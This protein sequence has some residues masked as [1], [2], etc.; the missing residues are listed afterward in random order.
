MSALRGGANTCVTSLMKI[1][2]ADLTLITL[3]DNLKWKPWAYLIKPFGAYISN[4]LTE[5][6][7]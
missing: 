7:A 1:V 3:I 2:M 4:K 6:I 5:L